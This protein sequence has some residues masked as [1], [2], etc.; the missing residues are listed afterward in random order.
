MFETKY[1]CDICKS[2]RKEVN[3]WFVSI[4]GPGIH[5]LGFTE[6]LGRKKGNICL[7][8]E[9]CLHTFIAQVAPT[10][11]AVIPETGEEIL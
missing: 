5:I 9:N 10:L 8:G 2:V 3:K 11:H 6:K 7:C 1:S 4:P